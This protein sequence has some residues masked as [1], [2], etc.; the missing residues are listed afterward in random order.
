MKVDWVSFLILDA[1]AVPG[2]GPDDVTH[3]VSRMQSEYYVFAAEW[4]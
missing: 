2:G 4:L 3:Y 1:A